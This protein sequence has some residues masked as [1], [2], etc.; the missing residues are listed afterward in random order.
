MCLRLGGRL[1][2]LFV[3]S[4]CFVFAPY[5]SAFCLLL[6]CMTVPVPSATS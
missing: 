3:L 6:L 1:L 5:A 2:G 4:A